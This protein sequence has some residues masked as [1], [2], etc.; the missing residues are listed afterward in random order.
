MYQSKRDISID[1]IRGIAI[2][3]ML[4]ANVLGYVTSCEFHP[5]W[6]DV[7]SSFAA[8][9][10]V[11]LSGYMVAINAAKKHQS[12]SYY[13]LRGGMLIL[14]AVLI[15]S[16][17]WQLLPFA[18]FDVLYII[19]LGMPVVFLLKKKSIWVKVSF[20]AIILAI[21]VA[22]R[23]FWE[24]MDFPMEI[25]FLSD[26]ADYS[27]YTVFNVVKAVLYDGWFPIFPW[28]AVPVLGSIF[29]HFR[30]EEDNNFADVKVVAIGS[31]LA[32]IGFT[33]LYFGYTNEIAFDGLVKREPYGELFYPATIP[34]L[35][36]ATGVCLLIFSFVDKTRQSVVWQPLTIFGQTSLFNYILHSAIIAYI[37]YP[38]FEDNLQPI[39]I[40]W[41]VYG[42]LVIV[43]FLLSWG[44]AAMKKKIKS[45]NFLFN[46][47]FG[48]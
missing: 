44:V 12:S 33:W 4:G 30:K 5:L 42:L 43:S 13:L 37:I 26:E 6:F 32:I 40:G 22:L 25:E 21:T 35:T 2:F 20:I 46:F 48:G 16:V 10:F 19:G 36:G 24:Y 11:L 1:I 3:I 23:H 39:S 29:A 7:V 28:L 34:F 8:P 14:T 15:D 31:I 41:I 9:L 27:D 18:T 38:Y 17:L 47:Y 45:K